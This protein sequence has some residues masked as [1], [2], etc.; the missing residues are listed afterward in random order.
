[1]TIKKVEKSHIVTGRTTLDRYS[2][3]DPDN[4]QKS[5]YHKCLVFKANIILEDFSFSH[6]FAKFKYVKQEEGAT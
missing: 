4:S 1:V 2:S 3:I 5:I 6:F